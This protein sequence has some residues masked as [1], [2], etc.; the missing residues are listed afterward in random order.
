VARGRRAAAGGQGPQ[1]VGRLAN[2]PAQAQR[3]A[4]D[5]EARRAGAR[6]LEN[7]SPLGGLVFDPFSGSGTTIIAAE[8]TRRRCYAI[9]LEPRY[10]QVAI[11]RWEAFTGRKATKA[12]EPVALPAKPKAKAKPKKRRA[13]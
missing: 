10:V 3:R 1:A 8:R 4:P 11:E 2:R 6:A 5:D 12:G 13:A 7:S 9:E